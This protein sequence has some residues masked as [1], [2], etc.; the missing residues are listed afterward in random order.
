MIEAIF[1]QCSAAIVTTGADG[2]QGAVC[3]DLHLVNASLPRFLL[4]IL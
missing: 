1:L 3:N 4:K 2:L